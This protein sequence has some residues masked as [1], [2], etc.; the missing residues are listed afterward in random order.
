[1]FKRVYGDLCIPWFAGI[2]TE[3]WPDLS[4]HP[5]DIDFLVYEKIRWNY[6][7]RQ[8]SLVEPILAI[9]KQRGFRLHTV[10]YKCHDSVTYRR[11]LQRSRAMLFLCEHETQGIAYQEALACN[12]PVLAWDNGFWL[13]PL[14]RRFSIDMIPASSVPFFSAEC[15]ERFAGVEEFER[16]LKR[17]LQSI[18]DYQPRRFVEERLSLEQSADMYSRAYR[19]LM[20]AT[21]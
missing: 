2:D 18:Q 8:R 7:E 17:F 15:G 14:W 20:A 12:V 19:S 13:D 21:V 5:K 3:E 11:L 10:R 9:L 16:A 4:S 6:D 1:M